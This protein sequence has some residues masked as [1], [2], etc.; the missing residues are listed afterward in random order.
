[1]EA[2]QA[3]EAPTALVMVVVWME[4]VVAMVMAVA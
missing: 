4:A 3:A 1:M 2:P